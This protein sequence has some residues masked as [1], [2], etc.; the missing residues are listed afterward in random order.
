MPVRV[1]L[2]PP[3]FESIVVMPVF[4]ALYRGI[5]VLGKNL[6]NMKALC[7]LH[8]SLGHA[9]AVH[10]LQSGNVVFRSKG[11]CDAIGK[12]ISTAFAKTLGKTPIVLVRSARQWDR[13]VADNPFS[14]E[15]AADPTKVH[16][17]ICVGDP[18]AGRLDELLKR[19]GKREEFVIK[20]GIVYL[21]T[22]DGFGSSKIAAGMERA[23]GISMTFRN[24]R[25]MQALHAMAQA[26]GK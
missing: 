11:S 7:A 4:I 19:A 17:G 15:S 26:A 14:K 16:A 6:V 8:D 12:R 25:T 21:H 20:P 22:P 13:L 24:W 18:V 2:P 9:S 3:G 23:S 10:Y 5:N 1:R